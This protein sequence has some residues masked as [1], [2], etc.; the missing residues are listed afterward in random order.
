MK[1]AEDT[2]ICFLTTMGNDNH[3]ESLLEL[4]TN[5]DRPLDHTTS[6]VKAK[7][8]KCK[9][10]ASSLQLQTNHYKHIGEV[11]IALRKYWH[12]R[13]NI[14]SLYDHGICMTEDAWFGVT[15]E[16]VA[17]VIAD[18]M[19]THCPSDKSILIDMFSG[20]GGNTISFA[21]SSCWSRVIGIDRDS[22]VVQC[23]KENA[24]I[25]GVEDHIEWVEGDSF[26]CLTN[27]LQD[28]RKSCVIFA[29]PPWG[30]PG[31]VANEIFDVESMEPYPL[32]KL[33]EAIRS[34]TEDYALFLPR[35]SDVR[36]VAAAMKAG[37][38]ANAV[39]YCVSGASK[40]RSIDKVMADVLEL[41]MNRASAFTTVLWVLKVVDT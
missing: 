30:G 26:E 18:F 19:A 25:Y 35:T 17:N 40:V 27:L 5:L 41:I 20:A 37:E 2:L 8:K 21:L 29:S 28:T 33:Q 3:P 12:Q 1:L 36:Q 15:P 34:V 13:Y 11:P 9:R 14:F 24:K 16:P 32:G 31:Y 4:S 38:H 23:A 10:N 7:K 39:Q 22:E 6:Q